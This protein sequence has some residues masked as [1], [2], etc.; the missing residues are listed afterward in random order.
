MNKFL[1]AFM[2]A[3]FLTG[4]ATTGEG[5]GGLAEIAPYDELTYEPLPDMVAVE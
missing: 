2:M 3:L 4:C 5:G 1:L